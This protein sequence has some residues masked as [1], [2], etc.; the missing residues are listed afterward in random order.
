MFSCESTC[1]PHKNKLSGKRYN[2]TTSNQKLS[3]THTLAQTN[4]IKSQQY[5]EFVILIVTEIISIQYLLMILMVL[6]ARIMTEVVW[7]MTSI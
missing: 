3:A 1:N 5:I 4:W 2:D 6:M 7:K